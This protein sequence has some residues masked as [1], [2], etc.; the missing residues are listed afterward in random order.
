MGLGGII[1]HGR[2]KLGD[3]NTEAVLVRSIPTLYGLYLISFIP[4]DI[5]LNLPMPPRMAFVHFSSI[6]P[7]DDD[8][9]YLGSCELS[10]I[11]A[12]LG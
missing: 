12:Q 1:R 8:S 6:G 11:T 9:A 5:W 10:P 7:N 3:R 2:F 4:S